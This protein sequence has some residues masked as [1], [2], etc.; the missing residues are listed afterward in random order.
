MRGKGLARSETPHDM[1]RRSTGPRRRLTWLGAALLA[2]LFVGLVPP[3]PPARAELPRKQEFQSAVDRAIARG[4]AW[5]L[6]ERDR[7]GWQDYGG[8][9]TASTALIYHTLRVCGVPRTDAVM[10]K[11]YK[12][13]RREYVNA[14]DTHRL[15]TYT[16]ALIMMAIETHA[17]SDV[18][19]VRKKDRYGNQGDDDLRADAPDLE[20]MKELV[21]FLE[22]HQRS[23]GTWRYSAD[24]EGDQDYDHSNVQYALLGLKS[25]S[26]M[27]V[28]VATDTYTKAL[29]HLLRAQQDKGPKVKRFE[30]RAKGAT[31]AAE[32]DHARGWGYG[33]LEGYRE[34]GRGEAYGSMT[35]GSVGA[36]VIC[37]SELLGRRG[38]SPRLDRT[39]EESV[40][41]GIA[42]L[43]AEFSVTG[44]PGLQGWHFYYL[45]ALERAGVLAGVDYM[46]A[47]D[48][49]GE[50]AQFL[51]D[52]QEEPGSWAEAGPRWLSTCFAL[53]FLKRG[54]RPVPRGAVTP[55]SSADEINFDIA[56]RLSES[57][58]EDFVDLA[59]STWTRAGPGEARTEIER[60][61]AGV[62]ARVVF[63]LITRLDARL[64]TK[65][66]SAIGMLRAVT[67]LEF[68]YDPAAEQNVRGEQIARFEEWFI[69]AQGRLRFDADAG[70]LVVAPE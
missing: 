9:P 63:P 70:R 42:W 2:C 29:E 69:G 43:G 12:Q 37:R 48:W 1:S 6:A 27:G 61:T 20:W 62:G 59:L 57:D 23:G 15:R 7:D 36:V 54:T 31:G 4:V 16:A 41:D 34:G 47:H 18:K 67:A 51:V 53:L 39:A 33:S 52:E 30:P 5:L 58:F 45:Y 13:L 19:S 49:Y 66:A 60:R 44:N 25:A 3:A 46:G 17:R 24:G 68:E 55:S 32:I 22:D 14:R 56:K 26:R 38:Y 21:K 65:R 8:Y 28:D 50:G 35:A 40:R 10:E 11:T 64:E